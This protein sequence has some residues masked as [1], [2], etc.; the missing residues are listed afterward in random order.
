MAKALTGGL[1]DQL[2]SSRLSYKALYCALQLSLSLLVTSIV[3]IYQSN[4]FDNPNLLYFL[5]EIVVFTVSLTVSHMSYKRAMQRNRPTE[6]LSVYRD[7]EVRR[8]SLSGNP[9]YVSKSHITLLLFGLTKEGNLGVLR[10]EVLQNLSNPKIYDDKSNRRHFLNLLILSECLSD[11][12]KLAK[13]IAYTFN[14]REYLKIS[15]DPRLNHSFNETLRNY[16]N[17]PDNIF[18][19]VN[20]DPDT[21]ATKR[22]FSRVLFGMDLP[23]LIDQFLRYMPEFQSKN[24]SLS[25]LHLE[26]SHINLLRQIAN[27]DSS[28]LVVLQQLNIVDKNSIGEVLYADLTTMVQQALFD[29]TGKAS[30]FPASNFYTLADTIKLFT[31][32]QKE[33]LLE[34]IKNNWAI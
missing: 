8:L 33:N 18:N 5:P 29:E 12:K 31:R 14:D 3:G 17:A 10:D 16:R 9:D 15:N 20:T 34:I 13:L 2:E 22:E 26:T 28:Y 6:A 4:K 7:D 19:P 30:I 21:L 1:R 27:E 23:D 24:D 32:E 25:A 11:P